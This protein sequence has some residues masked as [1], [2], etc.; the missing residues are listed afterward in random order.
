[1]HHESTHPGVAVEAARHVA[2]A[3]R[4]PA[5]EDAPRVHELVADSPPLD[6]NS[7]YAYLLI[8]LHFAD[9]SVVAER[10]EQIA[11]FVSAYLKPSA[12]DVLFVWQVAVAASA[13]GLGLGRHMLRH[14]LAR[15]ACAG[16]RAIETTITPSNN[17]SWRL[18]TAFARDLRANVSPVGVFTSRDVGGT[19]HEEERLIRIGPVSSVQHGGT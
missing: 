18:F 5:A 1:M 11:G 6:L 2:F 13:R 12:P 3:L 17:A 8:G 4:P 7:T 9:T 10:E 16:V 19:D 14:V 15:P